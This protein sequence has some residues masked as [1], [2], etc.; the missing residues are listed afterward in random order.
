MSWFGADFRMFIQRRGF[1]PQGQGEVILEVK[2]AVN[3]LEAAD[4]TEF[5]ELW[6]VYG[7]AYVAGVLPVRVC[8]DALILRIC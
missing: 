6:S 7:R 2:P 8:L 5:G 1:Y 3:G 4:F